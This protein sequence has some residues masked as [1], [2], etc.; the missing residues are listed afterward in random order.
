MYNKII[1]SALAMVAI[2]ALSGCGGAEE[3]GI[4]NIKEVELTHGPLNADTGLYRCT[5]DDAMLVKAGESVR[6][7]TE[8][9]QVRV[10]HYQNS[11]EYACTLKGQA[12]VVQPIK[13]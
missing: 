1:P 3:W 8:D 7:M 13:G 4:D 6:P 5:M 10:W 9:T 2:F 12:V 11:Q